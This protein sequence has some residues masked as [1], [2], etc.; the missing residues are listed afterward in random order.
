M[1]DCGHASFLTDIFF[2]ILGFCA[3]FGVR[4]LIAVRR[5]RNA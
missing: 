1:F 5:R 2:S 4:S 3:G